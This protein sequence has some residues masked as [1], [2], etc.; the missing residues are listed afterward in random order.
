[1]DDTESFAIV[2]LGTKRRRLILG[3]QPVF[4][5]NKSN[6]DGL[7]KSQR[8]SDWKQTELVEWQTTSCELRKMLVTEEY[9]RFM[10]KPRFRHCCWVTCL[11]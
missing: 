6:L 7:Y 8:K 9:K 10:R 5:R 2:L 4:N 3:L 1:M 11:L